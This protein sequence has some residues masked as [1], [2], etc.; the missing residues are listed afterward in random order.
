MHQGSQEKQRQQ[1]IYRHTDIQE[2]FIMRNWF[3][4]LWEPT[5]PK[6]F[7]GRQQA[8]DGGQRWRGSSRRVDGEVPV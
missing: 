1:E 4:Q 3:T 8:G 6:I 7:E 5:S 2:G